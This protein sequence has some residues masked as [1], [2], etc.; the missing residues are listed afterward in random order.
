MEIKRHLCS[1][2]VPLLFAARVSADCFQNYGCM[3]SNSVA[4]LNK[5]PN[6]TIS[7]NIE[8]AP[9]K[10]F[11][12]FMFKRFSDSLTELSCTYCQLTDVDDYA[13]VGLTALE[14][15]RLD[16]NNLMKLKAMWF[17]DTASLRIL[18]VSH[19][20][21]EAIEEYAFSKLTQLTFI[22]LNGNHLKRVSADWFGETAPLKRLDLYDNKINHIEGDL[23]QKAPSLSILLIGG[24]VLDCDDIRN[25]LGRLR[26]RTMIIEAMRNDCHK[27]MLGKLGELVGKNIRFSID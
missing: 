13:F 23:F 6:N 20:K 21:V 8:H 4:D 24:N 26:N 10:R 7:I 9:L 27:G 22:R 5:L 12:K 3:K 17:E 19:S 25:L 14:K 16:H 18:E 11:N 15:L 2:I 1:L